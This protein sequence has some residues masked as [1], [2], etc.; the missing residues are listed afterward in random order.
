M[1][2][3]TQRPAP[4]LPPDFWSVSLGEKVSLLTRLARA[5]SQDIW[6]APSAW[7]SAVNLLKLTSFGQKQMSVSHGR[8]TDA[9]L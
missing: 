2:V 6:P 9:S 3:C 5:K 4:E 1:S 8:G 7:K